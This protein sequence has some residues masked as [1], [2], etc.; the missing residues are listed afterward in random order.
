LNN[1]DFRIGRPQKSNGVVGRGI[2]GYNNLRVIFAVLNK[3]RQ[4]LLKVFL[5]VPIQDNYSN[6]HSGKN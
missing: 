4:K 3:G 2:V 5:P 6:M 1:P